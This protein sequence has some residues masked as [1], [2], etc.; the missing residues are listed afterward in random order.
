MGCKRLISTFPALELIRPVAGLQCDGSL[1]GLGEHSQAQLE[2]HAQQLRGRD[3]PELL[4][5]TVLITG[6]SDD[7]AGVLSFGAEL[8][9]FIVD[10]KYST[11]YKI[12]WECKHL[13]RA[14]LADKSVTCDSTVC[15]NNKKKIIYSIYKEV[16]GSSWSVWRIFIKMFLRC[17][18]HRSWT[19][20]FFKR[21]CSSSHPSLKDTVLKTPVIS[22]K[23]H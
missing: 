2:R 4:K 14:F 13:T 16:K 9:V 22:I 18:Q 12:K 10:W 19:Y 8:A 23:F 17:K 6:T 15:Y 11:V 20:C 3:P 7:W 21:N 5:L 1:V